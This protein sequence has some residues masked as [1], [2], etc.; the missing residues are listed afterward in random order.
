MEKESASFKNFIR[1]KAQTPMFYLPKVMCA[2]T[3][4]L[5][6]TSANLIDAQIEAKKCEIES[7]LETLTEESGALMAL[8]GVQDDDERKLAAK[9]EFG[10]L[11]P[12]ED[13]KTDPDEEILDNEPDA[14]RLGDE[15]EMMAAD[16][17][18]VTTCAQ[19]KEEDQNDSTK[20]DPIYLDKKSE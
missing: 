13:N 3:E 12:S 2:A 4:K 1:T 14:V 18:T 16:E 19:K 17:P 8:S 5:L 11:P 7:E 20:S 10:P 15:E 9:I 6:E